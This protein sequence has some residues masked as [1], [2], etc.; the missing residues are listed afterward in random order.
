[1]TVSASVLVATGETDDAI[2]AG[3]ATARERIAF[4]ASTPAYEP[5]LELYGWADLHAEARKL[6]REG[7]WAVLPSLIDDEVLRTFVVVGAPDEIG[8]EVAERLGGL[9][10]RVNLSTDHRFTPEQWE[11]LLTTLHPA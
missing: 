7:R 3:I 6:T 8:P 2:T 10:D 11:R 1:M 5:V 4:Y 9:V